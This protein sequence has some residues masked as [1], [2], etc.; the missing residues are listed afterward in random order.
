MARRSPAQMRQDAPS[1]PL[2][3]HVPTIEG[4][5][6]QGLAAVVR[7][8]RERFWPGAARQALDAWELFLHDPYHRLF[9]P[10]YGCGI[11]AYPPEAAALKEP[12]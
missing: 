9:D 10:A 3:C 5:S 6:R 11:L 1:R 2:P 4:L 8:E 7:L 12:D